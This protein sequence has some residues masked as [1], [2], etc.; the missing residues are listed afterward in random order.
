MRSK[1]TRFLLVDTEICQDPHEPW[2]EWSLPIVLLDSI[3]RAQAGVLHEVF[4]V[5]HVAKQPTRQM[6]RAREERRDERI[7]R[8]RV[9]A[10]RSG[11]QL[12]VSSGILSSGIGWKRCIEL[13]FDALGSL[14][15]HSRGWV[16]SVGRMAH[17]QEI[18]LV[19]RGRWAAETAAD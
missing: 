8:S 4:C 16:C 6:Q 11:H 1:R 12:R 7:E 2:R 17:Q 9:S 14:V 18:P 10:L 5:F 3:E 15:I 13:G 19:G